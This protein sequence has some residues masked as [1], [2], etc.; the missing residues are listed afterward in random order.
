MNKQTQ[1]TCFKLFCH[2]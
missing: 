2:S 1:P